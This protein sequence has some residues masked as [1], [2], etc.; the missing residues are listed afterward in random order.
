ME[1]RKHH[2]VPQCWL[3]GF[4]DTGTKEGS[5]FVTDFKR[6]KQWKT[7][8]PNCGHIRDFY[9]VPG[10]DPIEVEKVLGEIEDICGPILRKLFQ[11][12]RGPQPEEWPQLLQHIA[13]QWSRVPA[14]RRYILK[15]T[16]SIYRK[17]L[18][19]E[20]KDPEQ[21]ASFCQRVGMAD[22]DRESG[23]EAAK[24]FIE[25]PDS[26]T[27]S[28]DNDWY[29]LRAFEGVEKTVDLLASRYWGTQ[30][31]PSGSFIACDNPVILDGEAGKLIGFKNAEFIVFPATR[32]ALLYGTSVRVRP[33]HLNRTFIAHQNTLTMLN[34]N[35]QVFSHVPDFCWEDSSGQYQTDWTLFAQDKALEAMR[36]L[37]PRIWAT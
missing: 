26:F 6:G 2:F 15:L 25:H 28:A 9:R 32:H 22:S 5:I 12:T 1:P 30:I 23:Y 36:G 31:S 18:A 14:F 10:P 37:D 7:T 3:A 19:E 27:L 20:L 13:V 35:E 21:W 11:E 34:A 33:P 17:Q 29:V 24:A 16:D 8:P 4:T